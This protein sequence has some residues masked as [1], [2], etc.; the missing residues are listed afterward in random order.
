MEEQETIAQTS[1]T[2]QTAPEISLISD[3]D[4]M[5]EKIKQRPVNRAK[6]FRRTVLTVSFA[7]V[8][9]V[10]ACVTFLLLSPVINR[11]LN[12]EPVNTPDPVILPGEHIEDEVS[13]EDLIADETELKQGED[14]NVQ[15]VLNNYVFDVADY[16]EMYAS[17]K[18]I[19]TD[20][21]KS[22]VNV[23]SQQSG[24]DFSGSAFETNSTVSGLIVADNGYALLIV[25]GDA[26]L[27]ETEDISVTFHQGT[28]LPAKVLSQDPLTNLC[29]LSVPHSEFPE[30]TLSEFPIASLGSS[31]STRITGTPVIAIGSPDGQPGSIVYGVVTG[32]GRTIH[33]TDNNYTILSTDISAHPSASGF[34]INTGGDVVGLFFPSLTKESASENAGVLYAYGISSV[35]T[36]IERLSNNQPRMTLGVYGTDIPAAVRESE[37]IPQGAY[38]SRIEMNSPAMEAGIQSGDVIVALGDTEVTSFSS[39]STTLL[40]LTPGEPVDVKLLRAGPDGYVEMRLDAV[41][42]DIRNE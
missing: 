17:L 21:A 29:V 11:I 24:T 14:A 26:A 6:L 18:A 4:F 10:V 28:T 34:L 5:R 12:P 15:D 22:L 8:F 39:L 41:L 42:R 31:S 1:R 30:N 37:S 25:A 33:L 2:D 9:G 32:A 3:T 16:N 36:L 40:T 23:T 20:T 19:A 38:V 7:V 35:R 13:P 27:S